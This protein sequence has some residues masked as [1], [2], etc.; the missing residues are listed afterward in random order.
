MEK[1]ARSISFSAVV[2]FLLRKSYLSR[3]LENINSEFFA[4][5]LIFYFLH[6]PSITTVVV[7]I[8]Y[9]VFFIIAWIFAEKFFENA[10]EIC[11]IRKTGK[12]SCFANIIFAV[13]E[14]LGGFFYS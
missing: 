8:R 5:K 11:N 3:L 1:L 6:C 13:R 9:L 2:V 10:I 7:E 14:K 4:K 12:K